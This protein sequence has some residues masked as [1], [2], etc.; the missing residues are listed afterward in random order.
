MRRN[1]T[2]HSAP[3]NLKRTR[4]RADQTLL[5]SDVRNPFVRKKKTFIK[6]AEKK[7]NPTQKQI[8]R[9]QQYVHKNRMPETLRVPL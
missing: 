5:F 3:P 6:V 1:K 8:A 9:I 7:K 4:N 2:T